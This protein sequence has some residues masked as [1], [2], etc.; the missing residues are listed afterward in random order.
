MAAEQ[1]ELF[2]VYEQS[3]IAMLDRVIGSGIVFEPSWKSIP[4]WTLQI[5]TRGD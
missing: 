4:P 5:R 3:G 2:L 1:P